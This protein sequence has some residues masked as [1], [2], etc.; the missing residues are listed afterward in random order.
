MS[1][2]E[3]KARSNQY[4]LCIL[5]CMT[6]VMGILHGDADRFD[7]T[8]PAETQQSTGY[9]PLF[10]GR[11]AGRTLKAPPKSKLPKTIMLSTQAAEAKEAANADEF[12]REEY[13]QYMKIIKELDPEV[14]DTLQKCEKALGDPCIEPAEAGEWDE[15]IPKSEDTKGFP[16][17][18]IGSKKDFPKDAQKTLL[19]WPVTWYKNEM[20]R[21]MPSPMIAEKREKVLQIIKAVDAT[22]YNA[23]VKVD[24]T[25]EAHFMQDPDLG[26]AASVSTSAVD[27]LPEFYIG[28]EFFDVPWNETLFIIAHEMSHY[29]LGHFFEEYQLR[30]RDLTQD[31]TL[32]HI[33]GKQV[34][35]NLPFQATFEKSRQRIKE[36]ECDR[37]AV[38]DFGINL[39]DAIAR[40]KRG[41]KD[42][43][44]Y[45]LKAPQKEAFQRTHSLWLDR[46]KYLESLRNEVELNKVRGRQRTQVD[47]E[48]L[49]Q[50]YLKKHVKQ[51]GSK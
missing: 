50:K 22:L 11:G 7:D 42:Q 43:K 38:I 39:D 23:I 37:M 46:V 13:E 19:Q 9:S 36:N 21:E 29:A 41:V 14:H 40:A 30:H 45:E 34:G 48:K 33:K 18:V 44:E 16:I 51:Y 15:V 20:N 47:W 26:N 17:M 27:G 35:G 4:K 5:V 1:S 12:P 49:A 25:G 6:M 8:T 24:P 10:G 28:P 3:S 31:A 32:R 2:F